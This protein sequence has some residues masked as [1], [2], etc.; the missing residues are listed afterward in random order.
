MNIQK[1]GIIMSLLTVEKP[2]YLR[3]GDPARLIPVAKKTEV[4]L[5][6]CT[7]ATFQ[8]VKGFAKEL[9][10]E[11]GIKCGDRAKIEC[12]TEVS[13]KG[14]NTNNLR[15]DGLIVVTTNKN[16]TWRAL[17]EVKSG[18]TPL[19]AGK[20]EKYLDIAR[21]Q[22]KGNKIN[23]LITISNQFCAT[24]FQHPVSIDRRKKGKVELYHWSW[25]YILT[26]ANR[27]IYN[28]K[29]APD[30]KN[31]FILKE[32]VRYLEYKDTGVRFFDSMNQN[33][34]KMCKSFQEDLTLDHKHITNSVGS[35]HEFIRYMSLNLSAKINKPVSI[36]LS[37]E[38]LD[39]AK[40]WLDADVRSLKSDSI[41]L[42]TFDIKGIAS[43]INFEADI[44]SG[45]I[46]V[47]VE[48][49]IPNFST[50]KGKINRIINQLRNVNNPNK[51]IVS[52]RWRGKTKP[53]DVR[54]DK[55]FNAGKGGYKF[56]L[57]K[58]TKRVPIGFDIVMERD[59]GK[60]FNHRQ[61]FVKR[62]IKLLDDFYDQIGE[63]LKKWN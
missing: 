12:F 25:T 32:L 53:K 58:D 45:Y 44:I 6:S 18:K 61:K 30:S 8:S 60:D 42:A 5:T 52:S 27:L 2:D 24:P 47:Y 29:D 51:I 37:Q 21:K 23:A 19:T 33:W 40:T 1:G 38:H 10:E 28:E 57:L 14:D 43:S 63:D 15:P 36:S 46:T 22:R 55:I 9:L 39:D 7:L 4:K 11:I 17:V 20:I 34:N 62:C 49:K 3:S 31:Y 41:L 26:E 56:L 54:L 59:L 16:R 48:R 13:F 50:G 35:W